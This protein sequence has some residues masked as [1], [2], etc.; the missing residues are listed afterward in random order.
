[1]LL[2]IFQAL[3]AQHAGHDVTVELAETD[4]WLARIAVALLIMPGLFG[5]L[6]SPLVLFAFFPATIVLLFAPVV[7]ALRRPIREDFR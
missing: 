7:V 5:K 1:M 2:L 4:G 3:P 6:Y